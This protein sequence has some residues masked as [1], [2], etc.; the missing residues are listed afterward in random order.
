MKKILCFITLLL[1][2]IK[3]S[4]AQIRKQL[5]VKKNQLTTSIPFNTPTP[6][7]LVYVF[8]VA[9][10][11]DTKLKYIGKLLFSSPDS[12]VMK[13]FYESYVWMFKKGPDNGL[14]FKGPDYASAINRI[15]ICEPQGP[16]TQPSD[17][18][19][20]NR[21]YAAICLSDGHI[22]YAKISGF[23]FNKKNTPATGHVYFQEEY[24]KGKFNQVKLIWDPVSKK[25]LV[26]ENTYAPNQWLKN[27][28]TVKAVYSYSQHSEEFFNQ[29]R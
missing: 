18:N 12:L 28:A 29:N 4:P 14:N 16:I 7:K 5:P 13:D 19:L 25:W 1:M 24:D 6:Q 9:N 26:E 3:Y 2:G 22:I 20:I 21:D 10:D 23:Y 8:P 11:G 27:G 17:E 15:Y